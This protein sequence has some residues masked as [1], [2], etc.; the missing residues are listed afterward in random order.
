M[1]CV[2]TGGE[3]RVELTEREQGCGTVDL[4]YCARRLQGNG[5]VEVVQR[6]LRLA[7]LVRDYAEHVQAVGMCGRDGK[8]LS[9]NLLGFQ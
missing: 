2:I 4:E 5:P 8:H 3:R 9:I 1:E 7:A 6:G